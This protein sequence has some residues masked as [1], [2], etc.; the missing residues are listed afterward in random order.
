[1]P[2]TINV[3]PTMRPITSSTPSGSRAPRTIAAVPITK[4]TSACPSAYVVPY[5]RARPRS[6]WELVM[7]VIAAMWSQSTP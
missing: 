1:M 5:S 7:S 4:T 6:S 2:S 3:T